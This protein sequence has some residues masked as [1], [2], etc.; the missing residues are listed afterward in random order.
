VSGSRCRGDSGISGCW[1]ITRGGA[2]GWEEVVAG[3]YGERGGEVGLMRCRGNLPSHDL[4]SR[5]QHCKAESIKLLTGCP[6][7]FS[8]PSLLWRFQGYIITPLSNC[9]DL[10]RTEN[11]VDHIDLRGQQARELQSWFRLECGEVHHLVYHNVSLDI[12]EG[13]EALTCWRFPQ[14]PQGQEQKVRPPPRGLPD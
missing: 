10:A 2:W 5:C 11:I 9:L 1:E 7:S 3:V 8:L 13:Q 4:C 14:S 6:F 12:T